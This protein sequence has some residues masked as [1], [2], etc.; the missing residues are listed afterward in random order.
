MGFGPD[1]IRWVKLLNTDIY[2]AVIQAGVKSDF[3]KIERGCKQGDP[4]ASYL[5]LLCGQILYYLIYQN[6]EIKGLR[7]GQ[8]EIKLSQFADDTT[9]ILDGSQRSLEAALNTIEIFGNYSGLKMNTTKT[10]VVWIGDKKHSAEKLPVLHKLEWGTDKFNLL[11]VHFSVDMHEITDL[12]YSAILEQTKKIIQ[13]WK[14]RSLTPVGKITVIKTFILSKFN[15]LFSSIPSPNDEFLKKLNQLLFNYLWSGKPDKVKR[16]CVTQDY[17]NC[18]MRMVNVKNHINAFQVMWMDRILKN[19]S[20]QILQLFEHTIAP[21]S[22]LCKLGSNFVKKLI[23]TTHNQ[24]WREVLISWLQYLQKESVY[25]DKSELLTSTL[26]FNPEISTTELFYSKWYNNGIVY[27]AD[28]VGNDGTILTQLVLEKM[29]NLKINFLDY[30]RIKILIG[31]YL[32]KHQL[33]KG[34]LRL[35]DLCYPFIPKHLLSLYRNSNGRKAIYNKLNEANVDLSFKAKWNF[36]LTLTLNNSDWRKYFKIC[37]KTYRDPFHQWFQY[38]ILHRILGT[39]KLLHTVGISQSSLCLLCNSE[40]ETLI[41]LFYMC[42]KVNNLWKQLEEKILTF[43][44]FSIDLSP[45]TILLGYTDFNCNTDAVNFII[46][47][48]KIYIYNASKRSSEPQ[49][50]DLVRNIE[51][52]YIEHK[53]AA[54]LDISDERFSKTWYQMKNLFNILQ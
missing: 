50:L 22:N 28:I 12:N 35:M 18:G 46:I 34:N 1:F 23:K 49:I 38:R 53:L 36:D 42:P 40:V 20:S 25:N 43:T 29:Y 24:F 7:I 27:V 39:Q 5:F 4:I 31:V 16:L 14:R 10:K 41:H 44:G 9:L 32:K 51:K 30:Y 11:G 37:F 2:A 17:I 8:E 48:A 54:Q 33:V 45:T 52:V 26:W 19:D 6:I 15:Y 47:V 3:V 13:S 21:V